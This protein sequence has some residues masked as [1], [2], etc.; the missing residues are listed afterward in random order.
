[1]I[2][3]NIVCC[4]SVPRVRVWTVGQQQALVEVGRDS[5]LLLLFIWTLLS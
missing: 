4:F 2:H 1:M 5:L 3:A